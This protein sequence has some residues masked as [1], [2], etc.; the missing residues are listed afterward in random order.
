MPETL[1]HEFD[2]LVAEGA[3]LV[4]LGGF[5]FSGYNARLQNKYLDWRKACLEVLEQVGPIGVTY[6]SK[7]LADA[8][9]GYFFQGAARLILTNIKELHEKLK[10]SPELASFEPA[11]V[12]RPA[13]SQPA[14]SQPAASQ[15][16]RVGGSRVLKPPPKSPNAQQQAAARTAPPK[17]AAPVSKKVYVIGELNDPLRQQLAQF[18]EEV[19]LEEV[20]IDRSR[21]EMIDLER[22][23]LNSDAKFAFFVFNSDDLTYAMFELGHFVGKLGKNHVCVLHMSDVEVP[24]NIPGVVI[25]PIVVKLEEASM[26][27]MRDLKSSGYT[28]SF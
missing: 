13:A 1:L 15:P 19:G 27:M 26:G 3:K 4:P 8:N 20:P 25:R 9:G 16:T 10:T 7:I 28:I 21:G 12:P 23:D 6:K 17:T 18:I 11:P 22:I 2:R 14:A 24:K 5:E